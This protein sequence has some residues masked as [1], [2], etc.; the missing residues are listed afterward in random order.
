MKQAQKLSDF[1]GR[2]DERIGAATP[3]QMH[4]AMI[5]CDRLMPNFGKGWGEF[6]TWH[7]EPVVKDGVRELI[8]VYDPCTKEQMVAFVAHKRDM[9]AQHSYLLKL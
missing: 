9:L 3:E 8:S 6:R 5:N 7:F 4:N 2:I 1:L